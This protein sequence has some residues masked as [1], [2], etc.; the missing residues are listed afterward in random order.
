MKS[1]R[2]WGRPELES[3]TECASLDIDDHQPSSATARPESKRLLLE[4]TA[5]ELRDWMVERGHPAYRARQVLDWVMRRRAE[6]FEEMSDL[7]RALRRQLEAEWTLFGTRVA[8]HGVSPDGTDKLLLECRD[9]RRIECV[10]MAEEDRRTVC[11]STQ[12][13]CGMGCVFCASGLKGV[14]RNLTAGE[15]L[16]QVLRLRN[17]LPPGETVTHIVVM[18]MGESLANLDN[19]VAALDRLCSAEEGLGMGQRRV[20]IST[21]GPAREDAQAGRA[22][23]AV[24]PGGLAARPDRGAA[25]RARADQREDR[26]GR[27]AGGGRRYFRTDRPAGD[28]RVRPARGRQRPARGRRRRWPGCSQGA[29]GARQPDPVQPRGGPAVRAAGPRGGPPVRGDACEAGASA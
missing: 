2:C 12:V 3:R 10:L 15:I 18:G 9:G 24:S 17:L 11:I 25:Q 27:R 1:G 20:T 5:D 28:L 8:Y 19:L 6:S 4:A 26:P 13:G 29:E 7:P 14:E 23:P 22:G 16:E 21:V